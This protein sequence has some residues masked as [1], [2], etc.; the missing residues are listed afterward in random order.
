M[1]SIPMTRPLGDHWSKGL[2]FQLGAWL[3]LVGRRL[4]LGNTQLVIPQLT[5]NSASAAPVINWNLTSWEGA[6]V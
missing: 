4:C 6:G 1:P 3:L 5:R 2:K